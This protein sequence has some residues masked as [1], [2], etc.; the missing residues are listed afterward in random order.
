MRAVAIYSIALL[1]RRFVFISVNNR[2]R[3]Q[4]RSS[5]PLE[6]RDPQRSW[7]EEQRFRVVESANPFQ[8]IRHFQVT[9]WNLIEI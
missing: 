1:A 6:C 3:I 4:L 9:Y 2:C 7:R 8:R 5:A